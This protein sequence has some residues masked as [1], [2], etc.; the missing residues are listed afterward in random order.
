MIRRA[1][2]PLRTARLHNI[3]IIHQTKNMARNKHVRGRPSRGGPSRRQDRRDARPPPPPK[4]AAWSQGAPPGARDEFHRARSP[5]RISERRDRREQEL[6]SRNDDVYQFRGNSRMDD[7]REDQQDRGQYR[8]ERFDNHAYAGDHYRP[9]LRSPPRHGPS[10]YGQQRRADQQYDAKQD[11]RGFDFSY[12]APASIAQGLRDSNAQ[13]QQMP[14][15]NDRQNGRGRGAYR[16]RGGYQQTS[17]KAADRAFLKDN[18]APTPELMPGM[19]MDDRLTTKFRDINN[20]SDSEEEEDVDISHD[21]VVDIDDAEL[22]RKKHAPING[23]KAADGDSVP[24]WSN[25]D[26]YTALPPP[27]ASDRKKKD[28]VKLIRKA[29][30]AADAENAA[31]SVAEAADF[32]SFN[33]D[34]DN[35]AEP[36]DE[37]VEE[38]EV[39]SVDLDSRAR[40]N[41]IGLRP[42]LHHPTPSYSHK[43]VF[44]QT[45][46]QVGPPKPVTIP[47]RPEVIVEVSSD[48]ALGSRKRTHDD[49][50]KGPP[51]FVKKKVVTAPASGKIL[52]EWKPRGNSTPWA[53][54]DHAETESMGNWQV[55]YAILD[56]QSLIVTGYTKRFLTFTATSGLETS[57]TKFVMNCLIALVLP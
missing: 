26:P 29:R 28:V 40:D 50:I 1:S 49:E 3:K 15:R 30:V 11:Q 9:R 18:R 32:I 16:G 36:S 13:A 41:P 7:Y 56:T 21:D 14:Q 48:P 24:R 33:F 43:D 31:K 54:F 12:D 23:M 4:D 5:P 53:V 44:H 19:D 20:I 51:R 8:N 6:Y 45:L 35:D 34:D 22:P 27:D 25:P 55:S 46:P 38:G 37:I 17:R 52:K 39:R 10:G 2:S 42:E 47:I 57:R